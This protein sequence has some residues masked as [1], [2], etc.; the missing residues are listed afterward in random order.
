[1]SPLSG[2][3]C[4]IPV[5]KPNPCSLN[6]TILQ[7]FHRRLPFPASLAW[8]LVPISKEGKAKKPPTTFPPPRAPTGNLQKIIGG[9]V[10]HSI[11]FHPTLCFP[12]TPNETQSAAL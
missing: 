11:P 12:S 4:S 9:S 2:N 8:L 10:F 6:Y 1:M 5:P 7:L 3:S